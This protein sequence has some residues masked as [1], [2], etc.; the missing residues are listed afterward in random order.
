MTGLL[1]CTGDVRSDKAGVAQGVHQ[2][3][4]LLAGD[5]EDVL[6]AF[7]SRQRTISRATVSTG[8]VI[9]DLGVETS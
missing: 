7:V 8:L 3:D 2:V 4:V 9:A 5:A 6:D 1:R